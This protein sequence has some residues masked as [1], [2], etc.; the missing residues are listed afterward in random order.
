M[1]TPMQSLEGQPH[2]LGPP[3]AYEAICPQPRIQIN[4]QE[5]VQVEEAAP[6]LR[7]GRVRMWLRSCSLESAI[8]AIALG[9][10]GGL[11]GDALSSICEEE[12]LCRPVF[13]GIGVAGGIFDALL[14]KYFCIDCNRRA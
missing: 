9:A 11:L 1:I 14:L 5:T 2:P 8:F 3:P 4:I 10:L 6:A 13:M 12:K 7:E